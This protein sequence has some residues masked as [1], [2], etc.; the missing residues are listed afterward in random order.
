MDITTILT[1]LGIEPDIAKKAEKTINKEI[2]MEFLPKDQ[3][4]KKVLE[5]D[6]TKKTLKELQGVASE[7]ELYKNKLA[8]KETEF[9][10]FKQAVETEKTI[11]AKR[12]ILH[13]QL[14]AEG[15]NPKLI[16]LLEKEFDFNKIEVDGD[17]V[18]NW[19]TLVKPVKEQYAEV[20]GTVET[21]GAGV[22]NP[23]GGE[24]TKSTG[25]KDMNAFIRGTIE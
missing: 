6:E 12:D 18:K 20:F 2:P 24:A 8:D 19:E 1:D 9:S 22:T 3:Y 14:N 17:K 16:K 4:N 15:A 5:L 23:P 10:T 13:K 21:V 11:A 7:A 25:H